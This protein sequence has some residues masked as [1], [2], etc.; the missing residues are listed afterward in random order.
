M[1][2]KIRKFLGF[3][4]IEENIELVLGLEKSI[5]ENKDKAIEFGEDFL[6]IISNLEKSVKVS[7]IYCDIYKEEQKGFDHLVILESTKDKLSNI[8]SDYFGKIGELR[9]SNNKLNSKLSNLM[10]KPAIIE[11]ITRYK[12]KESLEKAFNHITDE[13]LKG[14][15]DDKLYS[16]SFIKFKTESEGNERDIQIDAI[17]KA[18]KEGRLPQDLFEKAVKTAQEKKVSKVMSEF[19]AGDLKSGSGEK[20]VDKDQAIAIAMSE[21]GISK[22]IEPTEAQKKAG[23][24]KKEKR[25]VRGLQISIENKK[26]SIRSGK[27]PQGKDWSVTMNNDYGYFN[28]SL[29]KDG[30]HIDV[31]LSDKP[32]EGNIYVIDQSN[33]IGGFDEHKVMMGFETKEDAFSNYKANYNPNHTIKYSGITEVSEE[34]FKKWLYKKDG[35]YSQKRKPFS[36]LKQNKSEYT[37]DQLKEMI[38]EH[39]RLI[40]V[41]T[42]HAEMDDKV[43]KELETQKEELV[44]YKEQLKK[45]D[46]IDKSIEDDFLI[47]PDYIEKAK[48]ATESFNVIQKAFDEGKISEE[49]FE[50]AT[51]YI[52]RTGS[53]GNYKYIYEETDSDKKK[54]IETPVGEEISV[55]TKGLNITQYSDK[56][57]SIGGDTYA[58]LEL[59]REIK[60]TTGVGRYLG[61]LKAWMFPNSVKEQ[62][63]GIIYSDVK[64]KGNDE[65]AEAIQNQKNELDKGTEVNVKGIDGKIEKGASDSDG[66]KYDIKTKDGVELKGIDEKIIETKP[67]KNDKELRKIN[68]DA[69]ESNRVNTEKKIYGIKPIENIQN[70]S[71]QEYLGMHGISEAEIQ[72]VVDTFTKKKDKKE[73]Q[74]KVSTGGT[75]KKY[76][77]K[78]QTEN[79]TKK[80]LISKLV[81]AHY[82]AVKK[83]IENGDP[84]DPKAVALYADLKSQQK[85]KREAMSEETKRK[86]SEALKK[87]K[88]PEEVN[89]EIK[90]E[91]EEAT[92]EGFKQPTSK[93]DYKPKNGEDIVLNSPKNQ[94]KDSKVLKTKDYTDVPALDVSIPKA[95]NILTSPKPYFIPNIDIDR[96]SRNS[97]TLSASK[98]GEDKYLVAL[99]GFMGGRGAY[100]YSVAGVNGYGNFAIMSLDTYV[101]TQNY[102]QIKAKEQFKQDQIDSWER[103]K[104]ETK[105][106][107]TKEEL[108]KITPSR[109][110]F[111]EE[112]LKQTLKHYEEGKP[113]MKRLKIL[114]KNKM[115]YDQMHMIQGMNLNAEG[116][117]PSRSETWEISREMSGAKKQKSIDLD[118]QQEYLETAYTKGAETSYGDSNAKNDLL[119]DYGVKV[120]RQN[121]DEINKDEINQIQKALDVTSNLF[122]NNIQMNKDFGLKI[123]HSGGVLMHARKAIGLFHPYYNAIGV[124]SQYGDNQFQ[125]TFGHEYAHFMD[126]SIGKNSGNS[127]AS[128]KEGS[129]ANKIADTFRKNMNE[130]QSSDYQNRTCECFAR[131]LEQYVATETYGEV[132]KYGDEDT[133]STRGNHVNKGVY[134]KEIKPLIE[135]FLRENK[136]ILKSLGIYD[137]FGA[138]EEDDF[139]KGRTGTYGDNATNRRLK[140]VGQK[141]GS[142]GQQEESKDGKTAKKEEPKGEKQSIDE[143]AKTASGS[144]LEIASKES[145]DPEIRAA[146]HKEL[147]R[148]EK[149]EKVQEETGEGE[150]TEE[151]ESTEK[152][153]KEPETKEENQFVEMFGKISTGQIENSYLMASNEEVRQAAEIILKERGVDFITKEDTDVI[154]GFLEGSNISIATLSKAVGGISDY[155]TIKNTYDILGGK[156]NIGKISRLE[157]KQVVSATRQGISVKMESENVEY[158]SR[159]Y[160]PK[161]KIVTNNSFSLKKSSQAKGLGTNIFNSQVDKYREK[162]YKTIK[163]RAAKSDEPGEE[164]NGYYTWA[165]LGYDMGKNNVTEFSNLISESKNEKIKSVE[166]VSELM[167]FSEGREFW[168]EN[169]FEFD[170]EFDLSKDSKSSFMLDKY[171]EEK[172]N[173]KAK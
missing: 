120:K 23:N 1:L 36:E 78:E 166:S 89:P 56:A 95:K 151:K 20:V 92:K 160:D 67:E 62:V 3:N 53:K 143:Q 145:K 29:G 163:T 161:N 154:N 2:D 27:N 124:S 16:K 105:L 79:L 70:Y 159:F 21:S 91:N 97:Y 136:E 14:N 33:N 98:I 88:S 158:M 24:Y 40:K 168:K 55:S 137:Y 72:S 121:G 131:A 19:K 169:G 68:N 42:P 48:D 58:N 17:Q 167:S 87:N 74:K 148:R 15:V 146:A 22:A 114:T 30:D 170:G 110:D 32:N 142:K 8:N 60:K 172:K 6:P 41:L 153:K 66:T 11:A 113:R 135:Q 134:E 101:A 162:G 103:R 75:S 81:F 119:D 28:R 125:F 165:R 99:D 9:K 45:K 37:T 122:G 141:Y 149:E 10:A 115:T 34:E 139:E 82:N 18:Y 80:Q 38:V 7:S 100:S 107:L 123:S 104:A 102:Y 128:D 47:D 116:A 63:L 51:K 57:F 108:N 35:S 94:T 157:I 129:T 83:A 93:V 90:K 64:N 130:T 71:L 156:E 112:R 52:K 73:G 132:S 138:F 77:K 61:K 126:Y 26:N 76:T 140:R 43:A 164:Y 54:E 171:M 65:K 111:M 84:V 86:I 155:E 147:D 117:T 69:N 46:K 144:S 85:K 31:F 133:Y 106:A 96:F 127:Y 12:H 59:M 4:N 5:Q 173:G 49:I 13:F 25:K 109:R 39:E 50:K 150:K 44:N 152:D 118:L